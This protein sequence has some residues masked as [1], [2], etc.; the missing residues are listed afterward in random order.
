[1]RTQEETH[2][3][4]KSLENSIQVLVGQLNRLNEV[5]ASD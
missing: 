4:M 3:V 5:P 1:M 2:M